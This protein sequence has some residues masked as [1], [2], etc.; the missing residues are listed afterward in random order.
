MCLSD[1]AG[2]LGLSWD[3]VKDLVQERL[4][5]DYQLLRN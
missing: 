5:K 1:V 2:L 3:P 4:E